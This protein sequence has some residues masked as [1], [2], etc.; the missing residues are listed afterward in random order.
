[1][2]KSV[3]IEL[4]FLAT[5]IPIEIYK[6]KP[7]RIKDTY[8]PENHDFSPLRL[9]KTDDKYEL[10]RKMPV[11]KGDY[12]KHNEHTIP[13]EEIVYLDISRLSKKS[14]VKDRYSVVINKYNAQV[15]VFQENLLGL[16]LIEFEFS[17]IRKM[18]EFKKPKCCL[19]DV[20]QDRTILGGQLAGKSYDDISSWL[21]KKGYIKL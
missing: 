18:Q 21:E 20:T 7:V 17:S 8:I 12:S 10:T 13:L 4:T 19:V 6:V 11:K 14:V 9:R 3:E 5:N 15:D 16:V 2:S 1:M